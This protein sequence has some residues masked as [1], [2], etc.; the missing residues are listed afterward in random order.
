[1][2][3]KAGRMS[4]SA[5]DG[6]QDEAYLAVISEDVTGKDVACRRC[7]YVLHPDEDADGVHGLRVDCMTPP[8]RETTP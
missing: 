4:S 6:I 7:G 1:M 5:A 2:T 3:E 8:A